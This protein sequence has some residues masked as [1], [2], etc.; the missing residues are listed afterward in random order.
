MPSPLETTFMGF[1][2]SSEMLAASS[3][4]IW[5]VIIL[6]ARGSRKDQIVGLVRGLVKAVTKRCSAMLVLL[7]YSAKTFSIRWWDP[8]QGAWPYSAYG[9]TKLLKLCRL[10][11]PQFT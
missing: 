5:C 11:L 1:A 10:R 3:V 2:L 8:F 9:A 4:S 7:C 6:P